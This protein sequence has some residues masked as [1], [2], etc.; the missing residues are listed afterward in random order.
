IVAFWVP[1][2]PV[3]AGASLQI[4]YRLHWGD[5]APFQAPGGLVWATR[6]G[7]GQS[8]NARR[9]VLDFGGGQLSQL[10]PETAVE[11]VVSTSSGQVP[12]VVVEVNQPTGGWRAFFDFVPDGDNPADLRCFLRHQDQVL[13]ETWSYR[14]MR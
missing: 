8:E 13:S 3:G 12:L 5:Q 11:A 4:T 9:F 2:D 10:S 6:I 1:K 14:W 7:P